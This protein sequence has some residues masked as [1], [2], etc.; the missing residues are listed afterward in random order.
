LTCSA[1]RFAPSAPLF[2]LPLSSLLQPS[3][4][5]APVAGGSLTPAQLDELHRQAVALLR[6]GK[7]DKAL[8]A[9]DRVYNATPADQRSRPLVLNRAIFDMVQKRYVVRGLRDL[10]AYL[11]KHREEDELAT[12]RAG[13]VHECRGIGRAHQSRRRVAGGVQGV[14]PAELPSRPQPPRLAALGERAG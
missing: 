8:A 7:T 10:T 13:R 9:F 14:G 5:R 6:D 1:S 3:H 2:S 11:T 4:P 12:N